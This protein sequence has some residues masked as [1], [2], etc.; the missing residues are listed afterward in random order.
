ME[1]AALA[2]Q[3]PMGGNGDSYGFHIDGRMRPNAA[4]DPSAE[5]YSVTP[6]YFRVMQ[7][8]VKRGR[9]FTDAD[10]ETS[11][12]VMLVSETTERTL[13]AGIDPIG[14][15]VRVGG[16]TSGPWRTIV[17]V[18][19]DVHHTDLSSEVT[20][21]M[22]LPQ[23]QMTDSFLV[24]TVKSAT[25]DASAL[26]ASIRAVLRDLDPSVPVYQVAP[27]EQLLAQSFAGRRFVMMLL[28][29]FAVVAL[30]LASVGLYGVVSF[31]VAQRTRE[32]G[33]RIALGATRADILRLILGS[34]ARTVGAG[35]AAGLVC[36]MLL[37]QSLQHLLFNVRAL[38]IPTFAS[39][40]L[41]LVAVAAVAH[42]LPI[43][44]ALHLDPSAALRQD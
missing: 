24:L 23:S 14:Q 40:A 41:T 34:G 38:D 18:V 6:E 32:V 3:I 27:L 37:T 9:L 26:V 11:Q 20:P 39:A 5:R 12:P 25:R 33:L 19:G 43:R 1:G 22:Y 35:L 29:G 16:A 15:R 31:A 36:A 4:E 28:G 8:P 2:G 42:W 17:G 30:L 21:Q 10:T 44:R 7:V 13:F